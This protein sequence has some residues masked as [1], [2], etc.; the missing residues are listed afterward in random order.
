MHKASPR[1][2]RP[3]AR[4]RGRGGSE[5]N[6]RNATCLIEIALEWQE[7]K[8]WSLVGRAEWLCFK[9]LSLS[10]VSIVDLFARSGRHSLS[11]T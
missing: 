9:N 3:Q 11:Y 2:R 10:A 7:E 6:V 4:A 5:M 1:S 8:P